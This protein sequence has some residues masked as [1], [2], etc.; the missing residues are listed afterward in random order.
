MFPDDPFVS[1]ASLHF[2][3]DDWGSCLSGAPFKGC[4]GKGEGGSLSLDVSYSP[5]V[6]IGS[7]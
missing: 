6:K 5:C 1:G 7:F 2:L 4:V 3:G